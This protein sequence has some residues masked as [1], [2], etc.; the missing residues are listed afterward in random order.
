MSSSIRIHFDSSHFELQV[1]RLLSETLR[2]Q[3]LSIFDPVSMKKV[4]N[5]CA[6]KV[7]MKVAVKVAT[8]KLT[9]AKLRKHE[10]SNS[11]KRISTKSLLRKC[12]VCDKSLSNNMRRYKSMVAHYACGATVRKSLGRA[13]ARGL[14]VL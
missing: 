9:P 8:K 11:G 5:K 2:R 1:C 4:A 13:K 7:A 12:T 10:R 3:S 6:M 14:Y